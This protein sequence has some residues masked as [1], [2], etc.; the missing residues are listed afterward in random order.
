MAAETGAVSV[1]DLDTDARAFKHVPG[2]DGLRALA[3]ILVIVFHYGSIWSKNDDG[4]IFPGGFIGVDVFF[5]LSGFLITSILVG[6]RAKT[7][8]VS[9]ARFYA[10]RSARLL[11]ALVLLL[12]GFDLWSHHQGVKWS[13]LVKPSAA[14]LFY[15]SNLA[16]VYFLK[17]MIHTGLSFT[18][19]LAIEEQFYLVWPA[20]LLFG[21]L[22]FAKT[23]H[24]VLI[25]VGGA[26]LLSALVRLYIWNWGGAYPSAYMRLDARADGLLLGALC[27]FLWRWRMVPT[28]WLNEAALVSL[29]GLIGVTFLWPRESGGMFQGGFTLVS[30]AVAV[31]LLAIAEDEFQLIPLFEW[32]PI[33]AI[34]RVSYG[35]Y[36][37]HGLCLRIAAEQLHGRGKLVVAFGGLV[38]TGVIVTISWFV[39]EQPFL[40]L[41][42]RLFA[43]PVAH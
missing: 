13:A 36:L 7:G 29:I 12:I 32:L 3:V 43:S 23:R 19:S 39:V 31:I 9:F 6:E 20:L 5:V 38:L 11:P 27:A 4:G 35:L 18:W 28:K 14:A 30:L 2:L 34:G 33:R 24:A 41:K 15:V 21:V 10:R 1:V 40:R 16:Q 42:D 25:S 26:A 37:W 22:R 8:R 17:S